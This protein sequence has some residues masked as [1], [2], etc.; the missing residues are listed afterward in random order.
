MYNIHVDPPPP[1]VVMTN[2]VV[3]LTVNNYN[4]IIKCLPNNNNFNYKWIKKN[5]VLPSRARGVNSPQLTIVNLKPEDSGDY[6]CVM[7]NSTGSISSKFSTVNIRGKKRKL[8]I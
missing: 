3:T 1:P 7:S 5:D 2:T 6:R 8:R 4:L